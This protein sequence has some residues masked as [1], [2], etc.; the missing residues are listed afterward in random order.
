MALP[1]STSKIPPQILSSLPLE[2]V[3]D[4]FSSNPEIERSV[5][6]QLEGPFGKI[7]KEKTKIVEVN[8]CGMF[9]L[10]SKPC[11]GQHFVFYE[12][13]NEPE[14]LREI[15]QLH[16]LRIKRL[17]SYYE[18]IVL[19]PGQK[20]PTYDE[21]TSLQQR[22]PDWQGIKIALKGHYEI[23]ELNFMFALKEH[24]AR[25]TFIEELLATSPSHICGDITISNLPPEVKNLDQFVKC[26]L[27]KKYERKM[28]LS[29][30]HCEVGPEFGDYMIRIF[31]EDK[32]QWLHLNTN[33]QITLNKFQ[34]LLQFF[35]SRD[36]ASYYG[37]SSRIRTDGLRELLLSKEAV[38]N[39]EK[40]DVYTLT[41]GHIVLEI[42]VI[43]KESG[44]VVSI[45]R[46]RTFL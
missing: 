34:E 6:A 25:T 13:P 23:L 10:L 40:P 39:P 42:E 26:F 19:E 17:T 4:I 21:T 29:L 20:L 15:H 36:T 43:T 27:Q 28:R 9:R 14:L 44:V 37:F 2:V 5:F 46:A 18:T 30:W 1:S 7:A 16:G 32:M 33:Y 41:Q 31:L 12:K 38:V 45:R 11:N 24:P 3:D 22:D 8:S 35:F